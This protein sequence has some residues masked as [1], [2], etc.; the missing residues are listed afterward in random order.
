MNMSQE[1]VLNELNR[2]LGEICV[3]DRIDRQ[4]IRILQERI[5]EMITGESVDS[6]NSGD[7]PVEWPSNEQ[8]IH[9]ETV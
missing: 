8:G 9:S 4:T 6:S 1:Q 7:S 5:R 2:Q 3:L